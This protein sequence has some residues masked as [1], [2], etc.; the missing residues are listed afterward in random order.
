MSDQKRKRKRERKKK[1]GKGKSGDLL[2]LC[3]GDLSFD[4]ISLI[5]FWYDF[6]LLLLG[7]RPALSDISSFLGLQLSRRQKLH[8][9]P[10][11]EKTY[12]SLIKLMQVN[13]GRFVFK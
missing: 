11:I 3:T 4:T 7:L 6:G 2:C 9:K 12:Q 8:K 1:R 10:R 13:F 5:D